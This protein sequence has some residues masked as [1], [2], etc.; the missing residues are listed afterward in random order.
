LTP[1]LTS[2]GSVAATDLRDGLLA[3]AQ[4]KQP[5]VHLLAGDLI[6]I[7]EHSRVAQ[8]ERIAGF[9]LGDRYRNLLEGSGFGWT[10]MALA[11]KR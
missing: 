7:G 1:A 11:R 9:F 6:R 4:V 3:H 10:R 2:F 5:N 8:D